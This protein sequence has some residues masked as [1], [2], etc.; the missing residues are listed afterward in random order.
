MSDK[1]LFEEWYKQR[2]Y[3]DKI[4]GE[5]SVPEGVDPRVYW[6][7]K[8]LLG[9]VSEVNSV[10][11]E[12]NWK[13]HRASHGPPNMYNL[14]TELA[15]V[16]KYVM[17]LWEVWGYTEED[18]LRFV[19][20][21]SEALARRYSQEKG[22]PIPPDIP[23]AIVDLDGTVADFNTS[24][25]AW[26][27][28]RD[29]P[30]V[31]RDGYINLVHTDLSMSIRYPDYSK[32]KDEFISSGGYAELQPYADSLIALRKMHSAGVYIIIATA[33]PADMYRRLWFDTVS[34][35]SEYKIEYDQLRMIDGDRI[36]LA[37]DLKDTNPV[38]MFEDNPTHIH[39]AAGCGIHV[40]MRVQ[41]YNKDI[42][43]EM[44]I[45]VTNFNDIEFRKEI[46]R[47]ELR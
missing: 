4:R 36:S 2:L 21:K 7:E 16:T 47:W 33:R 15:D 11:D 8:Y 32:F 39:R 29:I 1:K 19:G 22:G 25:K 24:F 18:M 41:D 30:L 13:R 14:A 45:P 37:N 34:W 43:G 31:E 3:N 6:S 5:T 9:I 42:N 10:L 27:A 26:C 12:L 38:V 17:S 44:I 35:L 23:I 40:Y 20:M 28:A 46:K